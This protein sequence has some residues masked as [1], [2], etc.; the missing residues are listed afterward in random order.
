[1]VDLGNGWRF[2]VQREVFPRER[3][4]RAARAR[5]FRRE[6]GGRAVGMGECSLVAG[7]PAG[8]LGLE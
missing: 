4:A 8:I 3:G 6:W 7:V 2:R 1:M 5:V